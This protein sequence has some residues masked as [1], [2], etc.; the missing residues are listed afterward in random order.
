MKQNKL[1]VKDSIYLFRDGLNTPL[2][3][4]PEDLLN[5][6]F[7]KASKLQQ[8]SIGL[9]LC[10]PNRKERL[11]EITT[12]EIFSHENPIML[13]K[14]IVYPYTKTEYFT[15]RF[16]SICIENNLKVEMKAPQFFANSS[17]ESRNTFI[18]ALIGLYDSDDINVGLE[19]EGEK[20]I[21]VYFLQKVYNKLMNKSQKQIIEEA[22]EIINE[23]DEELL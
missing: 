17:I 12:L 23:I 2:G 14:A 1:E 19:I 10:F 8:T 4:I 18:S 9:H 3:H 5:H 15:K 21:T 7:P 13:I 22:L 20:Q 11:S 6:I 16:R